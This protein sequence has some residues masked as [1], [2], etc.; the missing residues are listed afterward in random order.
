MDYMSSMS[1]A[2]SSSVPAAPA[3]GPSVP[4]TTDSYLDSM[5]PKSSAPQPTSPPLPS[6]K[7][8]PGDYLSSLAG[9][10]FTA[11]APAEEKKGGRFN[12][13]AAKRALEKLLKLA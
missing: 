2:P 9:T 12:L 7:A 10:A 11:T 4:A 6:A 1:S 3:V 5:S 8:P 13:G